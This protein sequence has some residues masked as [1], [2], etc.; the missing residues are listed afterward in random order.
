MAMTPFSKDKYTAE[1][2]S[3]DRLVSETRTTPKLPAELQL[4]VD[5]ALSEYVKRPG[6]LLPMLHAIQDK[7]GYIPAVTV[8][9]IAAGLN[10]SRAE[11]HGVI[12]F[13]HHFRSHR[14]AQHQIQIC[15][16]ESCQSMGSEALVEHAQ[17]RLGCQIHEQR[18][19]GAVSLE[20][21]Y[22][23]GQCATSPAIMI[24]DKVYAKVS[25]EKFDRLIEQL[26]LSHKEL[27]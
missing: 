19:D 5:A 1:P 7:L 12:T 21:V 26:A 22:C 3:Q 25:P 27:A 15:R 6:A 10:L 14:P 8:P 20:P 2:A 23:L 16:A 4:A 11:V 17:H 13:Y 24:D 18:A 9:V